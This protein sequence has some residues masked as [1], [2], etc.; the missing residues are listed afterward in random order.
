LRREYEELDREY[1]ELS[2]QLRPD[3]E[4]EVAATKAISTTESSIKETKASLKRCKRALAIREKTEREEKP[5]K[6]RQEEIDKITRKRRQKEAQ[7]MRRLL[8]SQLAII[9]HC[10]Y[11]LGA[12]GDDAEIDHIYPLSRGGLSKDTNLVIVCRK[13][14]NAKSAKTL[15]EFI[16]ENGLNLEEIEDTMKKLG[17]SF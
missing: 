16:R 11:C 8:E 4:E 1:K 6:E 14:N 9:P 15:L 2:L 17:K 13:C 7:Q 5:D 12:L 3:W 10:P